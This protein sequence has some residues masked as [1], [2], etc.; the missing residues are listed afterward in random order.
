M[1]KI[2][3]HIDPLTGKLTAKYPDLLEP[4]EFKSVAEIQ[5]TRTGRW[6]AKEDPRRN[7]NL[8]TVP[9]LLNNKVAGMF[10][11]VGADQ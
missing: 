8:F 5:G 6:S 2:V 9:G 10:S 7:G 3:L 4:E 11:K 1:K